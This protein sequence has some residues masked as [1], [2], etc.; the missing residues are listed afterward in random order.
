MVL[1]RFWRQLLPEAIPANFNTVVVARPL[2]PLFF[3]IGEMNAAY[4]FNLT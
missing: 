4:S 2:G 1:T 3:C